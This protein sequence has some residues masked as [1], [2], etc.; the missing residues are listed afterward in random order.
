MQSRIV[1]LAALVCLL[2]P[3]RSVA[4]EWSLSSNIVQAADYGTLNAEAAYSVS[5]HWT[6]NAGVK[7]NPFSY[8]DTRKRQRSVSL[9]TRYWPWH[10]YSGWWL[11]SA[12][13]YQEYN[14]TAGK[15]PETSEGDRIGTTLAAGYSYM[16]NS[17]LNVELGLGFWGGWDRYKIY[18]CPTCGV[19]VESGSK[20]FISPEDIILGISVI[21]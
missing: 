21:F 9:G 8:N 19:T 17:W 10:V 11:S 13:R 4:Q 12:A 20:F 3:S 15:S 5:R 2:I 1:L 16:I 18:D 7:Y 14:H 6:L